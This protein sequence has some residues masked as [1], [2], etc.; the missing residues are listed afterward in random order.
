MEVNMKY[1][2]D[3]VEGSIIVAQELD[4]KKMINIDKSLIGFDITDGMVIGYENGNY[5][6]DIETTERLSK[7]TREIFNRIK[8]D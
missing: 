8:E 1:V 4:S 3:R 2:V 5:Y 6:E 7:E